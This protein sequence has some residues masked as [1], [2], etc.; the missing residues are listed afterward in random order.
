MENK[1][2]FIILDEQASSCYEAIW[3]VFSTKE[4]AEKFLSGFPLEEVKMFLVQEVNVD[5][6]NTLQQQSFI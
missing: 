1:K 6:I 2:V 5:E 4:K 3:K